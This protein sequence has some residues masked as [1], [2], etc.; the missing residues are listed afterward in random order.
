MLQRRNTT[1]ELANVE[2]AIKGVVQ[3]RKGEMGTRWSVKRASRLLAP[4]L[5][6]FPD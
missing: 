5:C 3:H 6:I 4:S 2:A 1:G